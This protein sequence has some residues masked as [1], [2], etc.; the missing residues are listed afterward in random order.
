M[1]PTT[2]PSHAADVSVVR[3]EIF[4]EQ[5]LPPTGCN[6]RLKGAIEAGDLRNL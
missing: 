5:D 6:V 2:R 3:N 1:V 4:A